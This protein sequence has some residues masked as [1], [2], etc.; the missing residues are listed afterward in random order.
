MIV[1][2]FL[3]DKALRI[4]REN[5][6]FQCFREISYISNEGDQFGLETFSCSLVI[7]FGFW[8]LFLSIT[9]PFWRCW[10]WSRRDGAHSRDHCDRINGLSLQQV[11]IKVVVMLVGSLIMSRKG[12]PGVLP[13]LSLILKACLSAIGHKS[14]AFAWWEQCRH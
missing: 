5:L 13:P 3:P 10:P 12:F 6:M 2:N 1:R 14:P 7:K 4:F 8:W 9:P 11:Q